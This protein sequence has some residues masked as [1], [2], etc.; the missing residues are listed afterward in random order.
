MKKQA[1]PCQS[2]SYYNHSSCS[3]CKLITKAELAGYLR[4]ELPIYLS[5]RNRAKK[6]IKI[7]D[8]DIFSTLDLS[9]R[10]AAKRFGCSAQTISRARR[11]FLQKYNCTMLQALQ[12]LQQQSGF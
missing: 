7:N 1:I 6:A 12:V 2:C 10:Q 9:C 8:D 11:V 4:N 5:E 3:T